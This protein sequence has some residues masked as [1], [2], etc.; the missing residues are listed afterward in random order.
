MYLSRGGHEIPQ[1][2]SRLQKRELGIWQRRF[3]EHHIRDADDLQK[4]IHYIHY[5]PV[6]HALVNSVDDWPWSTVHRFYRQGDYQDFDWN[7]LDT[8]EMDCSIE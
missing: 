6:K 4:H 2:R 8:I 1:S 5:N 7:T 3:F